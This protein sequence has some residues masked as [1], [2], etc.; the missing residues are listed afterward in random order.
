M[1]LKHSH[2]RLP[3]D[4]T[5][6]ICWTLNSEQHENYLSLY[7][8]PSLPPSLPYI[9][10]VKQTIKASSYLVEGGREGRDEIKW[11]KYFSPFE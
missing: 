7:L 11:V 9:G 3:Q 10:S 1:C 2:H 4:F 5:I 6:N 8:P